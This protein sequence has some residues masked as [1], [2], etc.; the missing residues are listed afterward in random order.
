VKFNDHIENYDPIGFDFEAANVF[1]ASLVAQLFTLLDVAFRTMDYRPLTQWAGHYRREVRRLIHEATQANRFALKLDMLTDRAWRFRVM[2]ELGGMPAFMNWYRRRKSGVPLK[3]KRKILSGEELA[4][5][6]HTKTC[7]KASAH[8]RIFNDPFKMDGEGDFRL[9]PLPRFERDKDMPTHNRPDADYEY[10]GTLVANL[11]GHKA[12]ISV[13]PEE[14]LIFA[15]MEMEVLELAGLNV[16][17]WLKAIAQ[18]A[19][20]ERSLIQLGRNVPILAPP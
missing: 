17:A 12:P 1:L 20:A 4:H 16:S 14:F 19:D 10:D 18:R 2:R 3:R 7:G 8:P 11:R 5:R 9:A 13:W 6:A 15:E